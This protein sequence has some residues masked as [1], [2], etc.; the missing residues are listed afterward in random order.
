MPF[1]CQ[2]YCYCPISRIHK[3]LSEIPCSLWVPVLYS[4]VRH[5]FKQCLSEKAFWNV[6]LLLLKKSIHARQSAMLGTHRGR[7]PRLSRTSPNN[8]SNPYN[9]CSLAD[10]FTVFRTS[11]TTLNPLL[12]G[13]SKD[14][15]LESI[16]K[17]DDP[18]DQ[19]AVRPIYHRP[20][21]CWICLPLI[22]I[23]W[24]SEVGGHHLTIRMHNGRSATGLS[25]ISQEK[26][27]ISS[28]PRDTAMLKWSLGR[29]E[30]LQPPA[31]CIPPH[32]SCQRHFSLLASSRK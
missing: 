17:E 22:A 9:T 8:A 14:L 20:A 18:S 7:I 1:L 28:Q 30:D 13:S 2:Q 19:K 29:A 3:L 4:V 23:M 15:F 6:Q 32:H 21:T 24:S 25:F 27:F 5:L 11:T 26:Y 16:I 10:C 31:S 12:P